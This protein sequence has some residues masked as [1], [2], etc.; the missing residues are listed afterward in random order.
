MALSAEIRAEMAAQ[1]LTQ[2]KLAAAAG[3]SREALSRYLFGTRAM[4]IDVYMR[5]SLQLG[6]APHELMTRAQK[7]D[8]Q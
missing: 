7:R 8:E 2:G 5:L 6:L 4:P 1:G 3:I